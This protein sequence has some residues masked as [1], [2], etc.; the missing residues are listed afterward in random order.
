MI[1]WKNLK[2]IVRHK[3]FVF[4]AG[5][6]LGVSLWRLIKH[7][8]SKFTPKEWSGYARNFYGKRTAETQK[9]FDRSWLHHIHLNDH[10]WEHWVLVDRGRFTVL[11]MPEDAVREMVADWY[12][13]GRAIT[14]KWDASTWYEKNKFGL[15]LHKETRALVEELL[16]GT[17]VLG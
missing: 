14:G 2:Y 11:K 8:W 6:K 16:Y 5:R 4:L 3:W 15:E 10:H 17:E 1:H 9:A 12:G 7:D 13:A